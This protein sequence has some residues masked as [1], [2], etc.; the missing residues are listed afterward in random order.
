MDDSL[1]SCPPCRS[2]EKCVSGECQMEKD[3][4]EAL[5]AMPKGKVVI[6]VGHDAI[7]TELL[8]AALRRGHRT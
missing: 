2:P 7:T 5:A 6:A 8:R 4:M 1:I 3:K